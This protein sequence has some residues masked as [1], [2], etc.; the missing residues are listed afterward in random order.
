MWALTSGT[1]V[2]VA[3]LQG[4]VGP[5]IGVAISASLLPP[6]VNCVRICGTHFARHL[7]TSI[8]MTSAQGLFWSLSCT[9]LLKTSAG[10]NFTLPGTKIPHLKGE[11]FHGNRSAYEPMYTD[12]MPVEF[13]VSGIV[14]C[15]LTVVNVMCI[16]ITAI[17]VL[18][19]K[20]VAA[21]YTASPDLRRFWETDIQT[22]RRTNRST[23][24]RNWSLRRGSSRREPMELMSTGGRMSKKVYGPLLLHAHFSQPSQHAC[25]RCRFDKPDHHQ[26]LEDSQM[27]EALQ[28]A[29]AQLSE[30]PTYRKVRRMSYSGHTIDE[31]I[32]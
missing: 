7:L 22:V 13:F 27:G 8:Q 31:V 15:L 12:Y 5:L 17:A 9:W 4:S 24:R 23:I 26:Q 28:K 32:D 20:E 3:L 21:P 6:V 16:F 11:P 30:D 2:A 29:L 1:G 10:G 25:F 14:S 18:K 19:I